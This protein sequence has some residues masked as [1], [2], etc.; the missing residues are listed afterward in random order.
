M[1]YFP[2]ILDIA[3]EAQ[4]KSVLLFGPRQTGK[5]LLLKTLLPHAKTYSLLKADE[6]LRVSGDLTTIRTEIEAADSRVREHPVIIDEIQKMP[7]LLDEVH[8]MIESLGITFVLTGSSPRKLKRGGANLLGGRARTRHLY[9]LVS[10]E[11]P[12]FDLL[13]ACNTGT[14]PSIYL[15]EEPQEDLRSY[16]GNY[17]QQEIQAE[18]LV[19][20]IENFSRFLQVASLVN[21]ELL[22][23]ESLSSDT[24][25]PSNTLREYFSILE[26][27]LVGSLLKPLRRSVHRKS[28]SAAKFYFFDTGVANTLARRGPVEPKSELFGK[29]LEHFIHNEL[30]AYLSYNRD[31]RPLGF[32]R[33]RYGNEVD[34]TVDTDLAIEVKA[35]SHVSSKHLKGLKMLSEDVPFRHKIVVSMDPSP[36]LID[37]ILVL[38]CREFLRRLWDGEFAQG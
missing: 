34:F 16:C 14:L 26:D 17:L 12:D 3:S 15:S 5:T 8:Y 27:T 25:I 7:S 11:I 2:R 36:R 18:G 32:W 6:F 22:N 30:K 21:G 19:R 33:D 23:M 1:V 35:T 13:R 24:A 28:V 37:G 10:H 38:P 29:T 31:D 9:P 20:K 4:K